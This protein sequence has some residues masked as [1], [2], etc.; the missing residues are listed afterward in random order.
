MKTNN[1]SENRKERMVFFFSR[2][3]KDSLR[4]LC[5]KYLPELFEKFIRI[6]ILWLTTPP[7]A[8]G[9]PGDTPGRR[10]PGE[11]CFFVRWRRNDRKRYFHTRAWQHWY[12]AE[13]PAQRFEV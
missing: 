10:S 7:G 3:F 1:I 2:V 11:S 4:V 9:S 13:R 6:C 8:E 5:R 12:Q